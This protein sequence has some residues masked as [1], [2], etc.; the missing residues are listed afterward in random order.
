ML[1]GKIYVVSVH[2]W[3]T[4]ERSYYVAAGRRTKSIDKAKHFSHEAAE[5]IR[6]SLVDG[7]K[8]RGEL[9]NMTVE[10]IY[11]AI[12]NGWD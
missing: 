11:D 3:T 1:Y 2:N 12:R 8:K 5:F 7:F 6:E 4:G 9:D 10:L